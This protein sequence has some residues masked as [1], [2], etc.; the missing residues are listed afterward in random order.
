MEADWKKYGLVPEVDFMVRGIL[1]QL[2]G[3]L[4]MEGWRKWKQKGN[5]NLPKV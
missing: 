4:K 1:G 3:H 2:V 5:K